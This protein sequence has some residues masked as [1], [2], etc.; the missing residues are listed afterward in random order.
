MNYSIWSNVQQAQFE[1]FA[2][3]IVLRVQRIIQNN[4]INSMEIFEERLELLLSMY[5]R[6]IRF[7]DIDFIQRRVIQLYNL[8]ATLRKKIEDLSSQNNAA[9]SIFIQH[10]LTGG[11][12]KIWIN[13]LAI[14]L[15]REQG[16]NWTKIASIFGVSAK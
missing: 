9:I 15:L 4:D 8:Q 2:Q 5:S 10:Q 1:E 3:G 14:R 12:P 16:F 7:Y 6:L 11:R 13:P